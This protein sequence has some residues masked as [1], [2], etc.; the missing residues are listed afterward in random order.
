M[1]YAHY[2]VPV[3]CA[4]VDRRSHVGFGCVTPTSLDGYVPDDMIVTV[5]YKVT[6]A[7]P[8]ALCPLQP[9]VDFENI[10]ATSVG[11]ERDAKCLMDRQ[12]GG[13]LTA[14]KR[15]RDETVPQVQHLIHAN[16]PV[17]EALAYELM[18]RGRLLIDQC[19]IVEKKYG[20]GRHDLTSVRRESVR[21]RLAAFNSLPEELLK[22]LNAES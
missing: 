14:R 19:Q 21:R 1:A 2:R 17:I 22:S 3:V 4:L 11:D 6:L 9:F 13:D 12:F 18:N 8:G 20:I 15:F 16:W 7:G 5:D 10:K